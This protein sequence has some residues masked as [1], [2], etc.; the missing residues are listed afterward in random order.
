MY[1]IFQGILEFIGEFGEKTKAVVSF[2][3]AI[4]AAFAWVQARRTAKSLAAAEKLRKQQITL[5]LVDGHGKEV[6][7]PYRPRR[8]QL[9][10][11]EFL[12]ILGL[13]GGKERFETARLLPIFEEGD[14]SA[15]LEGKADV[16]RIPCDDK[17][18]IAAETDIVLRHETKA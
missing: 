16:I 10:R 3:S 18:F 11:A 17:F 8:D 6:I 4:F 5:I 7:I 1:E 12:G 14:F 15:V 9:G 2:V 13:Y